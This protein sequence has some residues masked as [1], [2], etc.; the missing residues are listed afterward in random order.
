MDSPLHITSGDIAG[1]LL[2][3]SGLPGEILVWRDILYDGPRNPGRPDENTLQARAV[4]LETATGGGL[5]QREILTTLRNQYD[6]LAA[7]PPDRHIVLWF[8][9][10]LFDQS[11]LTHI[12][13][14]LDAQRRRNVEL[15]CIDS[16]PGIEPFNGLGQMEPS[17]LAS[18]YPARQRVTEQQFRFAVS[19]DKAFA[20]QTDAELSRLAQLTDA[21]L[22]HVPAAV[23]RWLRERPDPETGLGRLEQLIMYAL[24]TG[25]TSPQEIYR[26][27]S[28]ADTP[29]QY[30]G[31][32][33]LWEKI[34][35]LADRQPPLVRIDGP[36]RRLP[37]WESEIPLSEFKISSAC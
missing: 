36:A 6:K 9:A 31:D 5:S 29:P 1:E 2:Q 33:T 37:Q 23:T 27:V 4:F 30:W 22:L 24:R 12:L 34:N 11:M 10:C 25:C 14:C 16:F 19:V 32:T 13:T 17:Q 21:P 7:A 3:K 20:D 18:C 28:G 26:F 15:I 8:D 35:G